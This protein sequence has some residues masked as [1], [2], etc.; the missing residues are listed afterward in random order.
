MSSF[1]K[2]VGNFLENH[3]NKAYNLQK[4]WVHKL[5]GIKYLPEN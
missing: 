3:E 5:Q 1:C 4:K 2:I